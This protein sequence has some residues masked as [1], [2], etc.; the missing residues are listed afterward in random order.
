MKPELPRPYPTDPGPIARLLGPAEAAGGPLALLGLSAADLDDASVAAALN[1]QEERLRKHPQWGTPESDEVLMALHAAAAQLLDEDVRS[2]VT[3]QWAPVPALHRG[4]A[5]SPLAPWE[6]RRFRQ[7]ARAILAR[8]GGLNERSMRKLALVARRFGLSAEHLPAILPALLAGQ[9]GSAALPASP[10]GVTVTTASRSAG[11][12]PR[13][14]LEGS[15]APVG[16]SETP[17]PEQMDPAVR[18]L[19]AGLILGGIA[20]LALVLGLGGVWLLVKNLRSDPGAPTSETARGTGATRSGSRP[21]LFP[22]RSEDRASK[23]AQAPEPLAAETDADAL[24][25]D[26]AQSVDELSVN[27]AQAAARFERAVS[28]LGKHWGRL[29]PDKLAAAQDSVVEFVYRCS[30]WPE[31]AAKAGEAVSAGATA[32]RTKEQLLTAEQVWPAVWSVGLLSR[33]ARERDLPATARGVLESALISAADGTV[34]GGAGT[35]AWGATAAA[36]AM[37]RLMVAQRPTGN[38]GGSISSP[39]TWRAWIG[40]VTALSG[41]DPAVR[42][43]LLLAGLEAVLLDG[44]EAAA[45]ETA[46]VVADLV[47]EIGWR[48]GD[49]SRRRLVRWFDAAG[50]SSMDL[51]AV[52]EALTSRSSAEG[53]DVSMVLPANADEPQRREMRDRYAAVWG[54]ES[55]PEHDLLVAEWAKSVAESLGSQSE[56]EAQQLARA[57]VLSR[58]CEAAGLLFAGESQA[59]GELV[60]KADEPVKAAV[61]AAHARPSARSLDD[62]ASDGSWGLRYLAAERNIPVRAG[63]LAELTRASGPLGPADAEP[64]MVEALRGSPFQIR[65]QAQEL[66]VKFGASPAVVNAALEQAVNIPRTLENSDLIRRISLAG[67]PSVKDPSWKVA[68]RRALVERLAEMLAAQTD[69]RV[70]DALAVLLGQSYQGRA[71]VGPVER[72]VS[73]P[74]EKASAEVSARAAR[75]SWLRWAQAATPS[76]REPIS[77]EQIARRQA[78]RKELASGLVQEFAAEQAGLCELMAYVVVSEQPAAGA[79]AAEILERLAG[80]RRSADHIFGQILAGE[81]AMAELWAVRLGVPIQ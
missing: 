29:S 62:G 60:R 51:H 78:G 50:V 67:L 18:L 68:V 42:S 65:K 43:R 4:G 26:L 73:P 63:L 46:R 15:P 24:A 19:R 20:V 81:R 21:E 12:A 28:G 16:F 17:L 55:G 8:F 3:A 39:E 33:L 45:G 79:Q 1:R 72:G 57:V 49:E 25:R 75:L 74:M 11:A 76:G 10:G 64:L 53:V 32:L 70:I 6:M 13:L 59:P 2:H 30:R 47:F 48:T 5:P 66:V 52:T 80:V 69:S 36:I 38:Q 61:A 31:I 71:F 37:P 7:E 58:L 77:L 9:V 27:S 40:V 35:Y 54:L 41:G 22:S 34:A 44:P 23:T 14:K 56:S